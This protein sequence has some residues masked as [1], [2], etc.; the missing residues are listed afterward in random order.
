MEQLSEVLLCALHRFLD[1]DFDSW[2]LLSLF[3][4]INLLIFCY[5]LGERYFCCTAICT[6]NWTLLSLQCTHSPYIQLLLDELQ[7]TFSTIFSRLLVSISF[8]WLSFS[9]TKLR[10]SCN[11]QMHVSRSEIVGLT[12]QKDQRWQ[13][14]EY[15]I[16]SSEFSDKN[17]LWRFFSVSTRNLF[18]ILTLFFVS[19]CFVPV[20]ILLTS[21]LM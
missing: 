5:P 6:G 17:L 2:S 3:L 4:F 18:C 16:F 8:S 1:G 20:V 7:H 13:N 15:E 9:A 11:L 12:T 10:F 14:R 21:S 19:V